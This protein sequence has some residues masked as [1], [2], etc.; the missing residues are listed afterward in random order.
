VVKTSFFF[1]LTE[2]PTS[3]SRP[4]RRVHRAGVSEEFVRLWAGEKLIKSLKKTHFFFSFFF[5]SKETLLSVKRQKRRGS[6]LSAFSDTFFLIFFSLSVCL[7][8]CLC[9]AA[10][11]FFLLAHFVKSYRIG[12]KLVNGLGHEIGLLQG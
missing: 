12:Q 3:F 10:K 2:F 1:P 5:F 4:I 11:I 7:S 9:V 6:S 8:V